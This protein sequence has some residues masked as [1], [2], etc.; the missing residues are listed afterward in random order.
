MLLLAHLLERSVPT[1][2]RYRPVSVVKEFA[3]WTMRELDFSV[4]GASIDRFRAN[5]SD[6][7]EVV[8]PTVHWTQTRPLVLT[9][10]YVDGRS[11]KTLATS[12][13]KSDQAERLEVARILLRTLL[14]MYFLDGFFQADPHPGNFRVLP[15]PRLV[16]F[17]F[18]MVGY[19]TGEIKTE[20]I[21]CFM[22]YVNR[23]MESYTRHL[24]ELANRGPEADV[25]GFRRDVQGL[26]ERFMFRPTRQKASIATF[27]KALEIGA[28]YDIHFPS[29]LVLFGRSIAVAEAT[30]LALS[31]DVDLDALVRPVLDQVVRDQLDPRRIARTVSANSFDYLAF[32]KELPERTIALLRKAE[33]GEFG[34]RLNLEELKDIKDEFDRQNDVRV[35]AI[36]A[37]A[38]FVGAGLLLQIRTEP[39][40]WGVPI[41]QLSLLTSFALFLWTAF[42]VMHRPRG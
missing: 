17:D 22:S 7:P 6:V 3:D 33:T 40:L 36:V 24:L 12:H 29:D 26:I 41:G 39:I 27:A 11:L 19:L 38:L 34:V 32:V 21:S 31:K 23:D 37:A 10:D 8:I 28:G 15:G 35:V 9:V 42:Q 16:M 30:A 13:A 5:F 14:K 4:E 1:L 2:A 18:G 25:S 20:L